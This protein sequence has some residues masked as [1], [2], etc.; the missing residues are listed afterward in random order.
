[1]EATAGRVWGK[2]IA[3]PQD[4]SRPLRARHS[5]SREGGTGQ[6]RG[7]PGPTLGPEVKRGKGGDQGERQDWTGGVWAPQC[8]EPRILRLQGEPQ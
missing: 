3:G 7:H 2:P 5:R 6:V 4:P 1:M 8:V